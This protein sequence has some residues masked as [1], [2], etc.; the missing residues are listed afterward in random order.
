VSVQSLGDQSWTAEHTAEAPVR[1]ITD[2]AGLGRLLAD[3]SGVDRYGL[4]TEFHRERTYYPRL[5][6]IQLA[7]VGGVALLDPLTVNVVPLA[8][9]FCGPATAVLHAADQDLEVLERASGAVPGRIFDTQIAAGFLGHGTPS[10]Q[11]ITERML[12]L[13]LP[14]GDRLTDWSRRPLSETQLSY[15]ASDVAHLLELA[16]DLL[17]HLDERGRRAWAEQECADLLQRER[18][19]QDPDTAWW[20]L[21]DSRQ[22]RG[23]SRGVA[24]SVAGWRERQAM[25]RDIPPRFVLPDLS[26]LSIAQRPPK[27]LEE[28]REVR[29]LDGR[30]LKGVGE[31]LLAAVAAGRHLPEA[32]LRVPR[33]EEVG[34]DLRPAVALAAAWVAQ[35]AKELHIDAGLL[36]T[37][38]DLVALLRDDAD[39]RLRSGWRATVVGE[40]VRRLT[41]GE[42][43]LAFDGRGGLVL[44]E[45]SRRPVTP[46]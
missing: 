20:R 32:E 14:K 39:A 46:R 5:A 19:N 35:M 28:L 29:G 33:T 44:E 7:W 38:S 6:L 16:D 22:L 12:H 41:A 17:E 2:D 42:A 37:R 1:L 23:A 18:G 30:H 25:Q 31:Q 26:L 13:R 11:T 27:T 4:D 40:P 43:A 24:Q 10:L 8:R 45:R 3:L 9:L 34:K 21:R 36:A 15:A